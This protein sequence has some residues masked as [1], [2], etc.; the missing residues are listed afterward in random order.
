MNDSLTIKILPLPELRSLESIE[1]QPRIV[2]DQ[3]KVRPVVKIVQEIPEDRTF[4]PYSLD[5]FSFE[6]L[7]TGKEIPP[8]K[9]V[10]EV[11][12]EEI[13]GRQS[14]LHGSL[15]ME[16]IPQEES[17]QTGIIALT[18]I[19]IVLV[20]L[21]HSKKNIFELIKASINYKLARKQFEENIGVLDT[22]RKYFFILSIISFSIFTSLVFAKQLYV[23]DLSV[24]HFLIVFLFISGL[25]LIQGNVLKI[26]GTVTLT[27]TMISEI[28]F[29]RQLISGLGGMLFV[30]LTLGF[31]LYLEDEKI[32]IAGLSIYLLLFISFHIRTFLIFSRARISIFFWFLY[33]C[34]FEIGPFLPLYI[35]YQSYAFG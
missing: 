3:V 11:R 15:Q 8:F 4:N 21:I 22:F 26:C 14:I 33:L 34:T 32:L 10:S 27:Q 5:D 29:H 20:F 9:I 13:Y 16:N 19:L 7:I 31:L 23:Y 18:T 1:V 17:S 35:V 25:L 6:E 30:P 12:P 24:L 28:S 2:P